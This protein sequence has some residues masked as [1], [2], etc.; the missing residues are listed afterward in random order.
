[1]HRRALLRLACLSPALAFARPV[2]AQPAQAAG[3]I[4]LMP[5]FWS[6]YD[7]AAGSSVRAEALRKAFFT[8]HGEVFGAAGLKTDAERIARW[9]PQF[10]LIA[11]QVRRLDGGFMQAY[12]EHTAHFR[13]QFPDFERDH[14][15]IYLMPSLFSFDGHLQPW[16][17]RMPLFIGLDGIVRYHGATPDLSVFLDHESFH[18]Y[19]AQVAPQIVMDDKA[20]LFVSLWVEGLATYVSERLNPGAS[21][22]HVLLDDERLLAADGA[23]RLALA[24]GLRAA[25]DSTAE[26]DA[27]RFFSAGHAGP[28][29]ARGGYLIGLEAARRIGHDQP[30]AELARMPRAHVRAR[31]ASTLDEMIAAKDA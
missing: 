20:P 29:P 23:T 16:A 17:G 13:A 24:Q 25:L 12:G 6:A 18:L 8:P 26:Q 22:L 27:T 4:D 28:E 2:R 7:G 14:A 5:A 30:L 11:A 31:L 19:H 9:L 21:P 15:P 1:M 10:D 3:L